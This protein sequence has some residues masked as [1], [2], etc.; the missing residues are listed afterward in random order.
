[1]SGSFKPGTR[2]QAVLVAGGEKF[3]GTVVSS[4]DVITQVLLSDASYKRLQ[5]LKGLHFRNFNFWT[6]NVEG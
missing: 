4:D 2:V 3:N 1:V 6:E 5:L